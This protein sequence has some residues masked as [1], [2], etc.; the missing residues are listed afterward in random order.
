MKGNFH[1]QK[2]EEKKQIERFKLFCLDI[3]DYQFNQNLLNEPP[4]ACFFNDREKISLELTELKWDSD[5]KGINKINQEVYASQIVENAKTEYEKLR[6]EKLMVHVSF[7]DHYGLN[8]NWNTKIEN[9]DREF[10]AKHICEIVLKNIPQEFDKSI[11]ISKHNSN[12]KVI[13]DKRIKR[14]NIVRFN[15][16][17]ENI[18]EESRGG[19]LQKLTFEK[20]SKKI[21][22]KNGKLQKYKHK[23]DKN[24]LLIVE[25]FGQGVS[26]RYDPY[27]IDDIKKIYFK[28]DFDRII[29][30]MYR[31]GRAFDL[32]SK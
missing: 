15:F 26:G 29:I 24:W 25:G 30:F 22:D 2:E 16:L 13:I 8:E 14:I 6:D 1:L 31:Y 20:V 7:V 12:D 19:T 27:S 32:K 28:S 5:T 3:K 18:W 9:N 23:Y 17:E 11:D 4:D 10:L 21:E